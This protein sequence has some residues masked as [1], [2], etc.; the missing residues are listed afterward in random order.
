MVAPPGDP[1]A[2]AKAIATLADTPADTRRRM[3]LQGRSYYQRNMAFQCGMHRTLS[4][5]D[6][7][8]LA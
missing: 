4:L 8:Y 1:D 6:G 3:G 5:L 2:L 7:T